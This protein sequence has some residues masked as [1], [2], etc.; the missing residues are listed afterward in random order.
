[1]VE[2]LSYSFSN[3]TKSSPKD[4]TMIIIIIITT[5]TNP[6]TTE[7]EIDDA[8][9]KIHFQEYLFQESILPIT[10]DLSLTSLL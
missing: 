9:N 3:I 1:M 7:I 5:P 10:S 6:Y 4:E 8:V 2:I